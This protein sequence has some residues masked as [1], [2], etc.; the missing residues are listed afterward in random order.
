MTS[1]AQQANP[2]PCFYPREGSNLFW[3]L[4]LFLFN[5]VFVNEYDLAPRSVPEPLTG[6]GTQP[7]GA[8]NLS[9]A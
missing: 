8:K 5:F 2:D 3:V 9:K 6:P 4:I 1:E 7:Q